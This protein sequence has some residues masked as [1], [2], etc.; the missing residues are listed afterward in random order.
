M[1]EQVR[2]LL[3]GDICDND[4]NSEYEDA[5][6]HTARTGHNEWENGTEEVRNE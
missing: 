1:T 4:E 6:A 5:G 2:C 3:C